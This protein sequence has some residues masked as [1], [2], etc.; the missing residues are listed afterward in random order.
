[1]YERFTDR[2]CKVMQLANQE[3]QRFNHEYIGTE[4]ILLGLVKEGTGVAANVIKNRDID[5][6]R[7]RLEV[8]KLVQAGPEMITMG[9]LEMTPRARQ[10][11]ECAVKEAKGLEHTYVGTEHI[12][13]GLI[14]VQEGI[15]AQ[16]LMNCGATYTPVRDDIV[17]LIKGRPVGESE[18]IPC[19][20]GEVPEQVTVQLFSE[21]EAM[22]LVHACRESKRKLNDIA[23]DAQEAQKIATEIYEKAR[24]AA[25][26]YK[27]AQNKLAQYLDSHAN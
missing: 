5:L 16:V 9:K 22:A 10:T 8:E 6:R 11:I 23:C 19:E 27:L 25:Q 1:M 13:L 26:N 3:A 20:Q 14:A 7:V 2:A 12:L 15:A 17:K 18:Q 21:S 24:I 4:H